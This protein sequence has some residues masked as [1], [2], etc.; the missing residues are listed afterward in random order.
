[1][2]L[3]IALKEFYNNLVSARFVI[4]FLLCLFLIPF[5]LIISI[6]DYENQVQSYSME[7]K[8]AEGNN[9]VRV[10]SALRPEI[11]K[12]PEPMSI[13]C[14]GI[15]FNVG[16]KVKVLLGEK[17]LLASGGREI[18][19]NPF[20]NSYFSLDFISIIIIVMSLLALIFTYDASTKEKELG[21]LK[22]ILSNSLS[23][24]KLLIGKV[25]GVYFTL[26]PIILVCYIISIFIILFSHTIA[27]S[28]AEW[29]R[30]DLLFLMS[31]LFFSLFIFIGL[32][33]S[34]RIPSSITSI[35]VC[36]FLW[37]VFIFII[38]NSALYI[39]QSFIKVG[40][41]ENLNNSLQEL[42]NEYEEK[43]S[44]HK[45]LLKEPDWWNRWNMND[46]DDGYMEMSGASRSLFEYYRSLK[47]YTEPLRIDYADKKWILQ[48]AYL[49]KLDE[50]RTFAET[51]SLLSPSELFR[52]VASTL[53]HTD[54][55]AH[56]RFLDRT[57]I[58]R[59]EFISYLRD[60]NIF[61]SFQYFS[62]QP[63]ETY[64]TADEIIKVRS[65]GRFISKDEF[66][67]WANSHN[68]DYSP[69]AKVDIPGTNFRTY[70]F[71]S[72]SD[73]PQFIWES[74]SIAGDLKE[75]FTKISVMILLGIILFYVS[76]I[77]FIRYDVR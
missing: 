22:L 32:F 54:V 9:K 46:G 3:T 43:C 60:R 58:Y 28:Q 57:R 31:I 64:M 35:I 69:L 39:A 14:G 76:F 17:P 13:F 44:V 55:N 41:Q 51:I 38:P 27:F 11:V 19:D 1:M 18:R 45:E 56:Y 47:E 49:D 53:C 26:L 65:G 2:V 48:K 30:V 50:Q 36:L 71:L 61:S 6:N 68:G 40:S 23:R 63:P 15:S 77:S 75:A 67:M 62:P 74:E 4:G 8:D 37:I 34:T 29:I 16:C 21:T 7:K 25:I 42:D 59:E 73:L 72:L 66:V 20:L 33:V 24:S 70:P 5:S 10:Y 52:L 12:H